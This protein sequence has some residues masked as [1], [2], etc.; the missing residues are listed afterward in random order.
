M[1][2]RSVFIIDQK[3]DAGFEFVET[4]YLISPIK[5]NLLYEWNIG[6]STY[7]IFYKL[8]LTKEE[9]LKLLKNDN[10]DYIYLVYINKS[11]LYEYGDLFI[12][13]TKKK[14]EKLTNSYN[15]TNGLLI[16]LDKELR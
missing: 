10:C 12:N 8:A 7:N 13:S 6:Y 15:R 16:N 14:I 5:T 1:L 2:F 3:L 9:F 11:F 4:K